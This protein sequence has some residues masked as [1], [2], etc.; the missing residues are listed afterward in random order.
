MK[1]LS[2]LV[3]KEGFEVAEIVSH[4]T[5]ISDKIE[6]LGLPKGYEFLV[7]PRSQ[8]KG[9]APE[10]TIYKKFVGK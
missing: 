8:M 1:K 9:S 4:E 3:E 2:E 5:F 10:Y 7:L 6:Q